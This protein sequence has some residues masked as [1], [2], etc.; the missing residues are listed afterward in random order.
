MP[1]LGW[2]GKFHLPEWRRYH[3]TVLVETGGE[4]IGIKHGA[5]TFDVRYESGTSASR[6]QHATV[7]GTH[8]S[9]RWIRKR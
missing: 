2:C 6:R 3:N 5:N 1:V 9:W 7:E 8:H 4:W